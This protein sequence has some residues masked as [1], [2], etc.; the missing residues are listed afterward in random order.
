MGLI[1]RYIIR[2]F[3]LATVVS[4]VGFIVIFVTIDMMEKLDKFIDRKVPWHVVVDYYVNFVPQMITLVLPISSAGMSLYRF[5]VPFVSIALVISVVAVY[6]NGWIA[7]Q[8]N[9]RLLSLRREY[10]KDEQLRSSEYNMHMQNAPGEFLVVGEFSFTKGQAE[11]VGLYYFNQTDK[12]H[13]DRRIDATRM[14]WDTTKKNWRLENAV[15]RS[16]PL[17][18]T[19]E[20]LRK[21]KPEESEVKL[22]FTP[23][24][25]RDRQLKTNEL[26]ELTTTD[27]ARRIDLS[28]RAGKETARDEVDYHAKFAMAFTSLIV[29][30]FGVPFASQKKRGGLALEFAI[31]IGIAFFY[32]AF[33]KVSFTFGYSGEIDPILTAWM[34]NAIFIAISIFVI[35]RVQK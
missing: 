7:P 29:V 23:Q 26:T 4:I 15:E 32:L 12:T 19:K 18:S 11:R 35:A 2:Q 31:A 22:T 27:L 33:T 21:L 20:V 25:L 3:I 34:A 1:D 10:L 24:D 6:F 16:F 5:M 28:K 30:L 8:A 14:L 17:N 9:V 13:L